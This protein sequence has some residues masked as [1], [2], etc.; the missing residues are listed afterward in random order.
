MAPRL[1]RRRLHSREF[2]R[3]LRTSDCGDDGQ[4]EEHSTGE[5]PQGERETIRAEEISALTAKSEPGGTVWGR[6]NLAEILPEPTPMTW[7]IVRRFM[8]GQGGYGRMFADFGFSP[9]PDL[10]DECVYD[11]VCGRPYMNLSREP[12]DIHPSRDVAK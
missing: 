2:E 5:S 3:A 12:R 8:S 11:L 7:S 4:A 9:D 10:N 6:F 1:C